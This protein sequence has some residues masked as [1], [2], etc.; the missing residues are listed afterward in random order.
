MIL[1]LTEWASEQ[2]DIYDEVFNFTGCEYS[3]CDIYYGPHTKRLLPQADVVIFHHNKIRFKVHHIPTL[4]WRIR[5]KQLWVIVTREGPGYKRFGVFQPAYNGKFNVT[6]T[7]QYDST[8]ITNDALRVIK[9]EPSSEQVN[10][11]ENKTKGAFAYISHCESTGY[12]RLAVI[13]E[14]SKYTDVDLWGSCG[15]PP[16]CPKIVAGDSYVTECEAEQQKPYRFYLAFENQICSSYITEKFWDRLESDS[17]FLPIA[18][19][20]LSPKEYRR[21]APPNSFIHA[22]NYPSVR[23]LGEVYDP[24]FSSGI[25]FHNRF[26]SSYMDQSLYQLFKAL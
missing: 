26:V 6:M 19:G 15:E 20:T 16:P 5:S 9:K 17:F 1:G 12:D 25:I 18:I 14:L 3:N 2:E 10:Y 13:R 7:M 8:F 23:A 22:Y 4:P 11:A 24:L 21:V